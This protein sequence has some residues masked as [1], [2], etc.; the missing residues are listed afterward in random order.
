M[1]GPWGGK[2]RGYRQNKKI[3]SPPNL[4]PSPPMGRGGEGRGGVLKRIF[5]CGLGDGVGRGGEGLEDF[6]GEWV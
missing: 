5:R 6:I 2:V 4:C 1:D 3:Y